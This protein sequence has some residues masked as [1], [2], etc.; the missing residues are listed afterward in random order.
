[1]DRAGEQKNKKLKIKGG[2]V[3]ITRRGNNMN[4]FFLALHVVSEIKNELR[5]ISHSQKKEAKNHQA[6]KQNRVNIQLKN[7]ISLSGT[8]DTVKLQFIDPEDTRYLLKSRMS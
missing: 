6:L 2:L 1:M 5:E 8:F 7:I 3:G 4:K